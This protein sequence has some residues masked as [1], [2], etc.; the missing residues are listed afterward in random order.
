MIIWH[1][2]ANGCE[3]RELG[4]D[5]FDK[6]NETNAYKQRLIRQLENLG[7]KVTVEEAA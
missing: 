1:V 7:L 4:H 6:R 5:Y 2:L 3:Y